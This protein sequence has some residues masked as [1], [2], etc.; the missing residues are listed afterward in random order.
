[1]STQC[2]RTA[3]NV[4]TY[5]TIPY[6]WTFDSS[7]PKPHKI[8]Q[9]ISGLIWDMKKNESIG[10]EKTSNILFRSIKFLANNSSYKEFLTSLILA[11]KEFYQSANCAQII[12]VAKA[13]GFETFMSENNINCEL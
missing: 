6:E 11:D 3:E 12:E 13:R 1:M 7:R 4:L 9:L 8:S 10:L 2:L 5:T